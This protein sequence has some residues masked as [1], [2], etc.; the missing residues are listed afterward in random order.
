MLSL[1]TGKLKNILTLLCF[2]NK[3]QTQN[4]QGLTFLIQKVFSKVFQKINFFS[5]FFSG[6]IIAFDV[7]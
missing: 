4:F 5:P 2:K 1:I 3:K 6:N 7:P